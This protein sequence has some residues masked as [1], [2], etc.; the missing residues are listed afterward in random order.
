MTLKRLD[1]F[2]WGVHPNAVSSLPPIIMSDLT[3]LFLAVSSYVK[4][5]LYDCDDG[6]SN[7]STVFHIQN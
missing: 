4:R 3:V 6:D 1:S 5:L 2:H 7:N